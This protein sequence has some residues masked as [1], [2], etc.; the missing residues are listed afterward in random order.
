[1]DKDTKVKVIS[2]VLGGITVSLPNLSW[3]REWPRKGAAV[4]V[5]FGILE[6]GMYDTGFG[7]MLRDG[8]LYIEDMA[9]KR[10][11]GLEPDEAKEPENIIIL[12]DNK[13]LYLMKTA[14]LKEL[15]ST[16]S[17]VSIEQANNL[18]QYAIENEYNN[19][20]KAEIIKER[21][22]IDI[23]KSILLERANK[24]K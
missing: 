11:L 4:M 16:L 17:K 12:T 21:T 14:S 18:A 19:L 3:I 24:E 22:G 7:N 2:T 15:R 20:D 23:I 5:P 10:E 1:M 9:V 8:D 6:E 13:M